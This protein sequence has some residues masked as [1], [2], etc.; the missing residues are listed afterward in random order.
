MLRRTGLSTRNNV[1]E[2]IERKI[3]ESEAP[4]FPHLPPFPHR[5]EPARGDAQRKELSSERPGPSQSPVSYIPV[6]QSLRAAHPN[7]SLRAGVPKRNTTDAVVSL[8]LQSK[9]NF[10]HLISCIN[11]FK[12]SVSADNQSLIE[13]FERHRIDGKG[14]SDDILAE[15]RLV[16]L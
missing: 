9:E 5:T 14:Q 4:V 8:T 15:L 1:G 10:E 12:S 11:S 16:K 7:T 13:Q 2:R 6:S 3:A